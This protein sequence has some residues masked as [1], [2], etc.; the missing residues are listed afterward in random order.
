[1]NSLIKGVRQHG[2]GKWTKVRSTSSGFKSVRTA[3]DLK[4]KWRNL[5]RKGQFLTTRSDGSTRSLLP[6]PQ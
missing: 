6:S 4:D 2:I 1:M 5:D 3:A